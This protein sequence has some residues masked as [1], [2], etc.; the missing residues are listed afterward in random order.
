MK[1]RRNAPKLTVTQAVEGLRHLGYKPIFKKGRLKEWRRTRNGHHETAEVTVHTS[2]RVSIT[3]RSTANGTKRKRH[4][5]QDSQAQ[6]A[7]E[8]DTSQA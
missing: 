4:S 6:G 7:T 5:S 3:H 1:R 2:G 8:T